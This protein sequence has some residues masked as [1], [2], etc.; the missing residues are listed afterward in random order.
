MLSSSSFST[1]TSFFC[2]S[3]LL[4]AK[5]NA[6]TKLQMKTWLKNNSTKKKYP[7]LWKQLRASWE[8][9]TTECFVSSWQVVLQPLLPLFASLYFY[10]PNKMQIPN[11]KWKH[12]SKTI[13]QPK[14]IPSS[15]GA[16]ARLLRGN[17][18]HGMF[19]FCIFAYWL[20]YLCTLKTRCIS[21]KKSINYKKKKRW[22]LYIR[23]VCKVCKCTM[24]NQISSKTSEN[25]YQQNEPTYVY[26]IIYLNKWV[27]VI[28]FFLCF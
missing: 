24:V 27:N 13:Q 9:P 12:S 23:G 17:A 10:L 19:D 20:K 21:F 2:V 4:P 15:L 6:N 7:H 14:K 3:V 5:Q 22:W 28:M 25:R 11:S 26:F 8:M 18:H 1:V 16:V